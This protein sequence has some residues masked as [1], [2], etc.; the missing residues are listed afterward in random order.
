MAIAV[1]SPAV[2][3]MPSSGNVASFTI[4]KPSGLE[5][6]DLLLAVLIS[7]DVLNGFITP[8]GWTFEFEATSTRH[9]VYWKIADSADVAASNFTFEFDSDLG[10][11]GGSLLRI[12]GFE[13]TDPVF[14]FH[15]ADVSGSASPITVTHTMEA[16]NITGSLLI[17]IVYNE[18]GDVIPT[19]SGY[20]VT[21]GT[22]PTWTVLYTDSGRDVLDARLTAA[23]GTYNSTTQITAYGHETTDADG[24]VFSTVALLILRPQNDGDGTHAQVAAT[25]SVS[26]NSS[27]TS[28]PES[29]IVVAECTVNESVAQA[30]SPTQWTNPDKPI[31]VWT[32]TNKI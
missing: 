15:N 5:V 1:A 7:S 19:I 17:M 29:E 22:N 23:Y 16:H 26:D 18:D 30:T 3:D 10:E 12:T 28:V 8:S 24:S 14:D 13:T 4:N 2:R 32:N 21:G 31:G 20:F 27:S 25:C 11:G 9:A 6:G